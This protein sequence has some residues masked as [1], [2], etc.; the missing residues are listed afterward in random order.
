MT[1]LIERLR[2]LHKQYPHMCMGEAAD[3]IERLRAVL[4]R[5][6][7]DDSEQLVGSLNC[8]D[9]ARKARDEK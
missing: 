4:D 7:Q 9:I 8:R 1:D 5:I 6:A 2:A 3:E